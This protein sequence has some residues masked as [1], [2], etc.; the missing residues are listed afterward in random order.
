MY[1]CMCTRAESHGQLSKSIELPCKRFDDDALVSPN[2]YYGS[3]NWFSTTA[4]M[5]EIPL[6]FIGKISFGHSQ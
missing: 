5:D 6:G 1:V 4:L 3:M 2:M